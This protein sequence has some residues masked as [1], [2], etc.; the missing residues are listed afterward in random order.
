MTLVGKLISFEKTQSD[1]GGRKVHVAYVQLPSP[2]GFK[3]GA[4]VALL[5]SQ[6]SFQ[7]GDDVS[8]LV[9][10]TNYFRSYIDNNGEVHRGRFQDSAFELVS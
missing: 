10:P 9:T 7:A 6:K 2:D 8:E 1:H 5:L 4:R 3:G